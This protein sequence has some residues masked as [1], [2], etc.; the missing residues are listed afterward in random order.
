[1]QSFKMRLNRFVR[2]RCTLDF[3][4]TE[5]EER[6]MRCERYERKNK[7]CGKRSVFKISED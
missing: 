3:R 6:R 4:F 7:T 2:S 1:M 5:L